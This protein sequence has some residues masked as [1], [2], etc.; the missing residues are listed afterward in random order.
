MA[1]GTNL[2]AP[3][4]DKDIPEAFIIDKSC[5]KKIPRGIEEGIFLPILEEPFERNKYQ[6]SDGQELENVIVINS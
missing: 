4:N 5:P 3:I 1:K 2:T 6:P